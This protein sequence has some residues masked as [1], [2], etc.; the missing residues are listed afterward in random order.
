[1]DVRLPG[2]GRFERPSTQAA[3]PSGAGRLISTAARGA[4]A[5]DH[6]RAE[7]RA[8]RELGQQR[9]QV[10]QVTRESGNRA[11]EVAPSTGA[12][13]DSHQSRAVTSEAKAESAG[14]AV[15]TREF[16]QAASVEAQRNDAIVTRFFRGTNTEQPAATPHVREELGE[17]SVPISS[18]A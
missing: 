9:V 8:E 7:L 1:M 11:S 6:S 10:D 3:P 5:E 12:V 14:R 17:R 15:A 18:Y 2:E 4:R 13:Q 16:T